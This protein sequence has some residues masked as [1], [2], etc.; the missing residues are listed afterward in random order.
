[1]DAQ[2]PEAV[3]AVRTSTTQV[4]LMSPTKTS[5]PT[6]AREVRRDQKGNL[7]DLASAGGGRLR[8]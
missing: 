6:T 1:M 3:A 2:K 4:L 8:V 7:L 5:E